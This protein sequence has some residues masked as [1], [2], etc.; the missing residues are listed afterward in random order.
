MPPKKGTKADLQE[1]IEEL[2]RKL[3]EVQAVARDRGE[4]EDDELEA[5]LQASVEEQERLH[6]V[7]QSTKEELSDLQDELDHA[8][9]DLEQ[10]RQDTE[11]NVAR[12]KDSVW[13]EL[14]EARKGNRDEG[15]D[16]IAVERKASCS[17]W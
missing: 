5:E 12:A 9:W 16:H 13:Q 4:S 1:Q 7:V 15:R 17:E 8:R 11:L 10:Y 14:G 3:K 6:G 2:K